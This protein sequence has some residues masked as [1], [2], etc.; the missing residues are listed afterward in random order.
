MYGMSLGAYV[1]SLVTALDS[2][3]AVVI[4]GAPFVDMPELLRYHSPA[5]VRRRANEAGVLADPLDDVFK[6]VSPLAMPPQVPKRNLF[7]FAGIGDRMAT[8]HQAQ[9]LWRHWDRPS[10]LWYEGSHVG[11]V[12]SHDVERFIEDALVRRLVQGRRRR[13]L[14][15]AR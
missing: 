8:P 11:F 7:M 3:P 9:M 2:W 13:A 5:I 4:A 15:V 10:I 14:A 6:V 12:W 1:A